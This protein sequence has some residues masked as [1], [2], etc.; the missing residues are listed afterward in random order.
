MKYFDQSDD[1]PTRIGKVIGDTLTAVLMLAPHRN[2]HYEHAGPLSR[3]LI[4][5][6]WP[7]LVIIFISA[8]GSASSLTRSASNWS[9]LWM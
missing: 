6:R 3:P 5:V 4:R 8:M 1:K 9:V 7:C 2:L